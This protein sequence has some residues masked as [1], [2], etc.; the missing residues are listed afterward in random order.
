MTKYGYRSG[1][2]PLAEEVLYIEIP[3]GSGG[4]LCQ[5]DFLW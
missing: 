4:L 3:S 1:Y 2:I 5:L